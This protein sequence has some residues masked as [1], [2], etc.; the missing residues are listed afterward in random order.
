MHAYMYK[1][2]WKL[3]GTPKLWV[4]VVYFS[5]SFPSLERNTLNALKNMD[6]KKQKY[7]TCQ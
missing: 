7:I 1:C 6:D 4:S 5:F 2:W 3:T